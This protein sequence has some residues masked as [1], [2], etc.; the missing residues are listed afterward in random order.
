MSFLVFFLSSQVPIYYGSEGESRDAVLPLSSRDVSLT[1]KLH[2]TRVDN[3]WILILV[4]TCP[5]IS[6]LHTALGGWMRMIWCL[7]SRAL[8]LPWYYIIPLLSFVWVCEQT[9]GFYHMQAETEKRGH[10]WNF[11]SQHI[12]SVRAVIPAVLFLVWFTVYRENYLCLLLVRYST[13]LISRV[14]TA[15][16]CH[17]MPYCWV[18]WAPVPGSSC[19]PY[20]I[21]LQTKKLNWRTHAPMLSHGC[22]CV[23][24]QTRCRPTN[25]LHAVPPIDAIVAALVQWVSWMVHLSARTDRQT[26]WWAPVHRDS[27]LLWPFDWLLNMTSP[28]MI[29]IALSCS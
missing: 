26:D 16:P 19:P 27:L 25:K 14:F 23:L 5:L 8:K 4:W 11:F 24:V 2:L 28:A 1:A 9:L 20:F 13:P 29:E 17:F 18:I 3:G 7:V 6:F 22:L 12:I 15:A 21:S 10:N